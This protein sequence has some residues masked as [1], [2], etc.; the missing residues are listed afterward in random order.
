MS[1]N[2]LLALLII[3]LVLSG[4]SSEKAPLDEKKASELFKFSAINDPVKISYKTFSMIKPREWKEVV[5][6]DNVIIY[7]PPKSD[8]KD[9]FS[10]KFGIIV[11][12]LPENNT[13][14]LREITENDVEESIK[15][16]PGIEFS[17]EYNDAKLSQLDGLKIKFVNVV[18]GRELE[19]TQIRAMNG[20]VFYAFTQQCLKDECEYTDIFNEMAESFEWKPQKP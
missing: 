1:N 12:F 15:A 5:R 4:C 13:A 7:L 14:S 18:E 6:E 9:P 10:E 19:S 20:N 17:G 8:E 2:L 11:S 3:A 16:S